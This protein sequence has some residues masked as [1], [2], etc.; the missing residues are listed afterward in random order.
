MILSQERQNNMR[1]IKG[2]YRMS[3]FL[4]DFIGG[5]FSCQNM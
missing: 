1:V 5:N 3:P 4:V 2:E